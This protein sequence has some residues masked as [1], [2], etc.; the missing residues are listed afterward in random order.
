MY[1]RRRGWLREALGRVSH[2]LFEGKRS[3]SALARW[4][5]ERS[6]IQLW[7]RH[8]F[9]VPGLIDAPPPPEL[10][11]ELFSWFE[12]VPGRPLF[13]HLVDP[14]VALSEKLTLARQLGRDSRR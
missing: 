14:E 3:P 8:G 1:R 10:E 4:E 13:W 7:S 9:D 6:S 5:T 2:R 12:F 11:G